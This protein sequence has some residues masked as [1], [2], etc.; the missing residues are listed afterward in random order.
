MLTYCTGLVIVLTS[1][2]MG[3]REIS[4]L[5]VSLLN[6]NSEHLIA[7]FAILIRK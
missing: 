7:F 3:E 6:E 2:T 5:F 1:V 4:Q